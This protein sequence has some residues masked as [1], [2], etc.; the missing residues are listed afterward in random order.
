MEENNNVNFKLLAENIPDIIARFNKELKIVYVNHL[1]DKSVSSHSKGNNNNS[2]VSKTIINNCISEIENSFQDGEIRSVDISVNI[3]NEVKYFESRIVPE[4]NSKNEFETVLCITRDIT[5]WKMAKN[6]LIANEEKYRLLVEGQTDLIVKVDSE[7]RFLFVSPSYCQTFGKSEQELL[8]KKFTPLVH[9]DDLDNTLKEMEKLKFAPNTCYIEQR[10][11]TKDGWKWF[12]WSDKAIVDD[13]GNI[14]EVIG[15]GRNITEAKKYQQELIEA[16]EKAQESDRLKSAFLANMSHEIRTPMNGIIGFTKLMLQSSIT[17]E[18]KYIYSKTVIECSQQ[19]L[20]IVNDILDISKIEA[21]QIELSQ[22]SVNINQLLE[23]LYDLYKS[24]ANN[25]NIFLAINKQLKDN[26]INIFTDYVKLKQILNHLLSNA[27]KFTHEGEIKFGYNVKN[28]LLEFYV[29]D[30]GIGIKK[31]L[32]EKIFEQFRQGELDI[33]KMYGGTGLGLSISKKLVELLNG[34]IWLESEHNKGSCFYFS[35]PFSKLDSVIEP[36][37]EDERFMNSNAKPT[38]LIAE[39]ELTNFLFLH[40]LL[41]EQ[42][43]IVQAKNGE[44]A[45]DI[46]KNRDD[47]KLILMDLKM[48]K[49]DGF[50]A[51]KTIKELKSDIIIIAQTAYAMKKDREKILNL[52]CDDYVSKPIEITQL[53]ELLKKYLPA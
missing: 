1:L 2:N 8:G 50:E 7:N 15:V 17:D 43:N 20:S 5:E 13:Q 35:I 36:I 26:Q 31:E 23:E 14:K 19:L 30:T 24:K 52:G 49:I 27:I 41:N 44:E 46:C 53:M 32:H 10:A 4:K 38:I 34:K 42:Y 40:E 37:S 6:K 48:P 29:K 22:D 9:E 12:A 33:S 45:I 39:D 18:K 28:N 25:K 47:I 3:G 16:K 11:F 21:G 51:T